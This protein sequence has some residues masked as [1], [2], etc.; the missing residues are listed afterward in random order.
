MTSGGGLG[1]PASIFVFALM[2]SFAGAGTGRSEEFMLEEFPFVVSVFVR[3]D[4]EVVPM[5]ADDSTEGPGVGVEVEGV[6]ITLVASSEAR[7]AC[8]VGGRICEP[9]PDCVGANDGFDGRTGVTDATVGFFALGKNAPI[10]V[11]GDRCL[12]V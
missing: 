12:L 6:S 7:P 10:D 8:D 1:V 11:S 2:G 4:S 3:A 5:V 9:D